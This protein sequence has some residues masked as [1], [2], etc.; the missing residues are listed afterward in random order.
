MRVAIVHDWLTGMR[1][2][3]RCLEVFCELFPEAELYTLIHRRGRLSPT[4][5]AM[6]IHTSWLNRVPG[7]G[8]WYRR[9]LR[10]FPRAIERFDLGE[11]ELVLSSSHC[12]AKGARKPPGAVHVCY[13]YTPMRYVWDLYDAYFAPDRSGRLTRLVM[14]RLRPRLQAWDVA[15]AADVDHF[16]AISRHVAERIRRHYRREAAVI[17]PPV[18]AQ[19]FVPDSRAAD[20]Y[21]VVAALVPYKRIDLAVEA[22]TRLGRSLIVVGTG[23]DEGRLRRL[24]GP[25]VTFRGWAEATDLR[26][27]Y[28][29]CRALVFPGEEDFGIVPLEAM[30]CGRP[31][32]ALGRGGLLET[33]IG[34][35]RAEGEP[36]TGL[37]FAQQTADALAEAVLEFERREGD[38]DPS[39]IR[40]HALTFDRPIFKE[41]I[42]AYLT[43]VTAGS[44][45]PAC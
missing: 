23:P 36:P 27:L 25:N 33:V 18:D 24:A 17:H 2:G 43:E 8:R 12:V 45:E 20:Y 11:A 37:F 6:S 9:F 42:R 19:F 5:E 34:P 21:L 22:F 14:R 1:G 3:E 26:A 32:I 39:A 4:I 16:I 15:T 38:F 31:V 44:G 7:M 30:A 10:S 29:G 40:R 13:C 28:A 35:N 41:R